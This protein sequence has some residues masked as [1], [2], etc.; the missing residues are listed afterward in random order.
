MEQD[1]KPRSATDIL[2][3]L[4]TKTDQLMH[5]HRSLDLNIKI[6]SNKLNQMITAITQIPPEGEP[7]QD[8][9]AQGE[10]LYPPP[11]Q[12]HYDPTPP[13]ETETVPVGFRR[14]SRPE[15]Y[16]DPADRG[17]K[18]TPTPSLP[19]PQ[20]FA[21][22]EG[23]STTIHQPSSANRIPVMQRIVD[24]HGKAIFMAEV[25]ITNLGSNIVEAK[26]RTNGVG[27]WQASLN[28]GQYKITLRK[29][30]SQNKEK[31]EV[32]Q[33]ITVDNS[34]PNELQVMIIK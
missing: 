10:N 30:Q 26:T 16:T 2:L 22:K 3:S 12:V 14:V 15:T 4:E 24:K 23:M 8:V 21:A 29:Q 13:L 11:A 5:L 18:N 27:K 31:L 6:L 20:H 7:E 25:E 17:K 34:T 19:Q 32:I 33:N 9:F 1:P 28:P